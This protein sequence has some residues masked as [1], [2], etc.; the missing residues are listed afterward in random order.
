MNQLTS[1]SPRKS[2]LCAN[3]PEQQKVVE[4]LRR[5]G[6]DRAGPGSVMSRTWVV[7]VTPTSLTK[8]SHMCPSR[9]TV[10][11]GL[12]NRYEWK[13]VS[14]SQG[15]SE[16]TARDKTTKINTWQIGGTSVFVDS[17]NDVSRSMSVYLSL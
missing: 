11:Y 8:N 15:S 4:E 13:P 1:T 9:E 12:L 5:A 2:D 17:M 6:K 16:K 10:F 3:T 7:W 14:V